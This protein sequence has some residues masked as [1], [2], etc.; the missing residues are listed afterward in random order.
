[1]RLVLPAM[2]LALAVGAL[3]GGRLGGLASLRIRWAPLAVVG[4]LLQAIPAE[5]A[6]G[7]ASLMVSFVALV[8]VCVANLRTAGFALILAGTLLNFVVIGVNRGM[9]VESSA[10]IASG[11]QDTLQAL[12][13]DG[14]AKHHL[15]GPADRLLFLGDVIPVGPPVRQAVSAGD[16]VAFT[17]VGY[18][19]VAA[20]LRDRR[21]A[22]APVPVRGTLGDA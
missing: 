13:E 16:V 17:G 21:R 2:L 22:R 8:A 18:L 7:Y 15:A 12:V 3:A 1:M 6:L 4:L 20:M 10:L 9:P 5:G 11:Q 19:I 14:G